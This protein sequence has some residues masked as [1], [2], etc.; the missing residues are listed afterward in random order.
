M[1]STAFVAFS[2]AWGLL[3][4]SIGHFD[5][6]KAVDP[7]IVVELVAAEPSIVTPVGLT[8]DD[9][10]RVI[11]VESHTHFRPEG[12]DGPLADRL[13]QFEDKDGDGTYET[14]TTLDEGGRATMNVQVERDGSLL[15][16]NRAELYRLRRDSGGNVIGRETLA[17]LITQGDYPHNG[18]SGLA[19][20]L[21]DSIYVGMGE[22][23]GISF[24]LEGADGANYNGGGE[25]GNVFKLDHD[26]SKLRRYATGFWNPFELELDNFGRLFAVDNDPDSRPPCRLIFVVD[27]GDYG[28]RFRN[29]RR[30]L[31]PFTSW[32]GE[33][34]GTLPMACG[35]GEAPS[36]VLQYE[37]DQ[38]PASLRGQLMVTSWGD[39]RIY[40]YPLIQEGAGVFSKRGT[41]IEGGVQFRPVGIAQAPDGSVFVSDWVD[42][43]YNLHRKGRVWRIRSKSAT[44]VT[45]SSPSLGLKDPDRRVRERLSLQL[46]ANEAGRL[47]L[48][49]VLTHPDSTPIA[50]ALALRAL[51]AVGDKSPDLRVALQNRSPEV[52]ALAVRLLPLETDILRKITAD[53]ASP[54]ARAEALRRICDPNATAEIKAAIKSNDPFLKQAA[55]QALGNSMSFGKLADWMRDPDPAIRLATLVALRKSDAPESRRVLDNALVDSDPLVRLVAIQW[56]AESD[57]KDKKDRLTEGLK[58]VPTS[59]RLAAAYVVALRKLEENKDTPDREL[60]YAPIAARLALDDSLPAALRAYSLRGLRADM[61]E[62]TGDRLARLLESPEPTVR[63]EAVRLLAARAQPDDLERLRRIAVDTNVPD[64]V[65]A[66]A[67]A[68]LAESA[69]KLSR[70]T[71]L[72]LTAEANSV[73]G[74]QAARSLRGVPLKPKESSVLQQAGYLDLSNPTAQAGPIDEEAALALLKTAGDA[75]EGERIFFHPKGPGCFR[76]H[77][78]EGRGARIGPDLSAFGQ[79]AGASRVLESIL[80]PNKEIA[81]QF[82][83]WQFLNKDGTI[84]VGQLIE[85]RGNEQLY[86]DSQGKTG[87]IKLNELEARAAVPTSIMP[88]NLSRLMTRQELRDLVEF[89]LQPRSSD[90]SPPQHSATKNP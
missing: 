27:G 6:P 84:V 85:D 16:A 56:V 33:L 37:S 22:N 39:H 29:G 81:P 44:G 61:P 89:L 36:G 86:A 76:C 14:V 54:E 68:G 50:C 7:G 35:T 90:E 4:Q 80:T 78:I 15:V 13:R 28:Y 53:N 67:V 23:M 25:G 38:L 82:A 77:Q 30:G 18:L 26:G 75:A 70:A 45:P 1:I 88:E 60:P 17:R 73:V 40:Q 47:Q 48:R 52:R 79:N 34:P 83:A 11:V 19:V 72:E 8:V 57:L 32:D 87:I 41:M 21:D 65:R 49:A 43:D 74:N 20:D 59:P 62:L 58:L 71:L 46:G 69:E 10:G 63:A 31:H 66:E 64:G 24:T 3:G 51:V 55:I 42:R 12:Y 2:L 9:S 5:I